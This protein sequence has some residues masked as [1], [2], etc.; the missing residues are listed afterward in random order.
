MP[1]TPCVSCCQ[2]YDRR[3]IFSHLMEGTASKPESVIYEGSAV[4]SGTYYVRI[5]VVYT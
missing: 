5:E 3:K 2:Q 1:W 4:R